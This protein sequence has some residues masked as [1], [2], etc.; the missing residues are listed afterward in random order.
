MREDINV[1]GK[2]HRSGNLDPYLNLSLSVTFSCSIEDSLRDYFEPE[3]LEGFKLGQKEAKAV[4]IRSLITV[5]NI[6]ILHIKRF[7][8]TDRPVKTDEIVS[9]PDILELKDEYFTPEI[10][11]TR[12]R[13]REASKSTKEPEKPDKPVVLENFV[14]T[15]EE[16]APEAKSKKKKKKNNKNKGKNEEVKVQVHEQTDIEKEALKS[17]QDI[18]KYELIGVIVHKGKNIFKGHYIAF[19][20][21][22]FGNWVCYDDKEHKNVSASIVLSQ[23]AYI[24]IYRKFT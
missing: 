7:L 12:M 9:Y 19:V 8:Y 13:A 4:K 1:E 20:Q 6:L 11:N 10:Q 2:K 24:L 22:N 15:E 21:D 14:K 5:P 16:K 18:E 3:T 17:F 23:Q